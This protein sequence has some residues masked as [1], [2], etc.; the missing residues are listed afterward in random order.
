MT[1][2]TWRRAEVEQVVDDTTQ[3]PE[4]GDGDG[5]VPPVDAVSE[6]EWTGDR[7]VPD[8]CLTHEAVR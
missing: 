7:H 6:G 1:A 2:L 4:D 3:D 8:H 5:D